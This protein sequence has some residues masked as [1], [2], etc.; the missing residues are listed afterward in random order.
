M[1][2][3]SATAKE[4]LIFLLSLLAT[5]PVAATVPWGFV[6]S[7]TLPGGGDNPAHPVLMKSIGDA[8]FH[9]FSIVHYSYSF[10][11]GFE[12]F[13][14]YFPLPYLTG[15]FLSLA[16]DP[17]VA[18]KLITIIGFIF[19]PVGFFYMTRW[20]GLGIIAS[21]AAGFFSVAFL[22]TEAHVMWGG[23][24][25]STLAGMIGNS[26]GFLFFVLAVGRIFRARQSNSFSWSAAI[27][28][29]LSALCHFYCL[30]MILVFFG[31]F[32]LEDSLKYIRGKL[33]IKE[34]LPVYLTGLTGG[35]AITWWF[36]PLFYYRKMSTDFGGSWEVALRS[37]FTTPECYLFGGGVL[38]GLALLIKDRFHS[39][40]LSRGLLFTGIY[41]ALFYLNSYFNTTVFVNIRLWPSIYFGLYFVSILAF[42]R[43]LEVFPEPLRVGALALIVLLTPESS[44]F[45]KARSWMEWN[46]SGVE[47]KDGA[48]DFKQIVDFFNRNPPARVTFESAAIS[49]GILGSIRTF[50]I[51]P[52][53]TSAQLVEGGIVNSAT[54]PGV[55]YTMQCSSSPSCAGWAPGSS[56]PARDIPRAIET[57]KALGVTY[58]ISQDQKISEEFE[59][60][61][62]VTKVFEGKYFKIFKLNE[63]PHLVEV[64]SAP[65]PIIHAKRPHALLLNLP[66]W[67]LFR[68]QGVL[69]DSDLAPIPAEAGPRVNPVALYNFLS[70]SWYS[71]PRSK[72]LGSEARVSTPE[73][74]FLHSF[75]FS[76][77]RPFNLDKELDQY[78]EFL[79][80][81]RAFSPELL[82]SNMQIGS[83]ESGLPL[84]RSSPGKSP[85]TINGVGYRVY[86]GAQ[87]LTLNSTTEIE[88]K[89]S[90]FRGAEGAYQVLRFVTKPHES[91]HDLDVFTSDP[92]LRPGLPGPKSIDLP[93]RITE[94]CTTKL[95]K[96]FHQMTL[97]TNCPGKPHLIKYSYYPK[98]HS[99]V[100][101]AMGTDGFIALTPVNSVTVLKHGW[102]KI[103][104]LAVIVTWIGLLGVVI[105]RFLLAPTQ[106]KP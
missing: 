74:T 52:Y 69:F 80:T 32:L 43:C 102:G 26:W 106:R 95:E 49:N 83:S 94:K 8:F 46:F 97:T 92:E 13:Q 71:T 5:I 96:E 101:L 37:T 14:F 25:S 54:F 12:A 28:I 51:L 53:L 39:S 72:D 88:F 10:W 64:Y 47:A 56:M 17:N 87:E 19:L 60:S 7:T 66:R 18:F 70:S 42:G 55:G 2:K 9:H 84:L 20:I 11:G 59:K 99:E 36:I 68:R 24:V 93:E 98:W 62:E 75:F 61:G 58:H 81:D 77:R 100:P 34:V 21:I 78:L 1:S 85:V 30:L 22:F 57:M 31:I 82:V 90:I 103:D 50:E 89:N 16:V 45:E 4:A 40:P 105:W 48:A 38:L 6:F 73:Q 91:F 86:M 65:L 35:L 41:V 23:N 3:I 63:T 29:A 44:H 104:Y 27:L 79:L 76:W 67:D 15:A 33:S